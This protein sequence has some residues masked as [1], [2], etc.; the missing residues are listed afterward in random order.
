MRIEKTIE[1]AIDPTTGKVMWTRE[2][3]KYI[4][5]E[6]DEP[7]TDNEKDDLLSMLTAAQE[8]HSRK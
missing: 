1:P 7:F 5:I 2:T 6:D 3:T 8:A 4:F